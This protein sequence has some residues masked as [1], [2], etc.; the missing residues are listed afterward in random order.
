MDTDIIEL[1]FNCIYLDDA[2]GLAFV[3]K[4][5][6]ADPNSKNSDGWSILHS[7]CLLGCTSCVNILLNDKRIDTNIK[8]PLGWTPTSM[9]LTRTMI[10]V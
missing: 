3:L 7:S 9:Q 8:G 6:K 1:L 5:P 4:N 10:P 2:D